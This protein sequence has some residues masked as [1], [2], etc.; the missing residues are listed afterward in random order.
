MISHSGLIDSHVH[1][2]LTET[3]GFIPNRSYTPGRADLADLAAH[4]A[5]IGASKLVI[6]QP[7]PYGTDNAATLAAVAALGPDARAIAVIDPFAATA[8]DIRDLA[9]Q[10]VVGMRANLKTD[11]VGDLTACAAYLRALGRI[12]AG[13]DM[14]IEVF[15]PL[16]S[17]CALRPILADLG[18]P[19]ILDHFAGLKTSAPTL[20]EDLA[21]LEDLLALPNIVLKASGACRATDYAADCRAL[22]PIAPRLFAAAPGRV[23]WGSDWPHTG[24]SAARKQRPVTEIEP[25]L[26]IDDRAGLADL[27]RWAGDAAQLRAILQDTPSALFSF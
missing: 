8:D 9:A 5:R 1:V 15:L 23:I 18:R 12:L 20:A 13:S 11:G 26:P 3:H 27:R 16:A 4:R 17:L 6:V 24:K 2:F 19:V 25:F 22:D 7:S 21:A 14:L 10:G